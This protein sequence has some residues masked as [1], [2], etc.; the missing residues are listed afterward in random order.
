MNLGSDIKHMYIVTTPK[1][2]C[3]FISPYDIVWCVCMTLALCMMCAY[4][5]DFMCDVFL[6]P[7]RYAW[8]VCMTLTLCVMCFYDLDLMCDVFLWPCGVFYDLDL[9]CEVFLWPWPFVCCVSMTLTLCVMCLPCV[10]CDSVRL[11]PVHWA[12]WGAGVPPGNHGDPWG[13]TSCC[14]VDRQVFHQPV[15]YR[16]NLMSR[17]YPSQPQCYH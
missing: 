5:L 12:L 17:P 7:W 1:V 10:W 6:W 15:T 11:A 9:M 13:S 14:V 4:D 8:C 16:S 2:S 3:N